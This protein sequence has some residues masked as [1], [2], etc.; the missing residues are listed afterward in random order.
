MYVCMYVC[1]FIFF[2]YLFCGNN[3]PSTGLASSP[4]VL[5]KH[6]GEGNFYHGVA[7]CSSRKFCSLFFTQISEHFHVY[8]MVQFSKQF[9]FLKLVYFF[10]TGFIFWEVV[11][12]F[13]TGFIFW[14]VVYF[15]AT[16]FY[17]FK[18]YWFCFS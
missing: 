15:L 5:R 13:K 11:Y 18:Q 16:W 17:F 6:H 3:W 2:A 14:K 10:K 7:K 12:F 9:H 8:V 4:K 1:L